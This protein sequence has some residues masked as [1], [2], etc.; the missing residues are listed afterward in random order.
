MQKEGDDRKDI[1]LA[2][3]HMAIELTTK[4]FKQVQAQ[5]CYDTL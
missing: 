1:Y 5:P 2:F 4:T 3:A